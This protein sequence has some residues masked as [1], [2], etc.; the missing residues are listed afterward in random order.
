MAVL[1]YLRRI[2]ESLDHPDMI[3][4]I[5]HYLLALPN[6]L[7][8]QL[9]SKSSVSDARKRKS[10]DL[11]SMMAERSDVTVTPLL[12]N[13][14]DLIL[15]CLRSH[16]QQTIHVT[17]QLVSAI[18]KRHHRYAVITLLKTEILPPNNLR[19]TIGAHEQEV[20]YIMSLAG[21]IGG[22]T[23]FDDIY[24]DVLRDTMSRL[25]NHPCSIKMVAPR[26]STSNQRL[27][28]SLPGAPKDV[29][30]HTLRP[31]DPLLN[32]LL[33]LLETFF[34]NPVETNLSVTETLVDLAV[35]GYMR[36]EGWLIRNPR[37]YTYYEVE[38]ATEVKSEAEVQ[39]V[40]HVTAPPETQTEPIIEHEDEV[41]QD[42][43]ATR[44]EDAVGD[45]EPNPESSAESPGEGEVEA[46]TQSEAEPKVA[47]ETEHEPNAEGETEA[48]PKAD[49]EAKPE[50]EP[51][52]EPEVETEAEVSGMAEPEV[53]EP[54]EK[55]EGQDPEAQDESKPKAEVEAEKPVE[56]NEVSM[57]KDKEESA[58]A[59]PMEVP[60]TKIPTEPKEEEKE[61]PH[62]AELEQVEKMK[63]CREW[64]QWTQASAPRVMNVLKHLE[65]QVLTYKKTIPRFDE[66]VQQRREAF[67]TADAM[68][69]TPQ[70]SYKATPIQQDTPDRSSFEDISRS[71]SPSRPSAL[72]GLA[73]R[74]LSELGTPSRSS[75]PRG[76]KELN[77]SSASGGATPSSKPSLTPN[78]ELSHHHLDRRKLA[79]SSSPS[80][81]SPN[82]SRDE[83]YFS[84]GRE[85]IVSSQVAAFAAI[86]QTILARKVGLPHDKVE[87]IPLKFDRDPIPEPVEEEPE[88]AAEDESEV[89][90]PS[91]DENAPAVDPTVSVSHLVTNVI[92]LQSFLFELASLVQVRAGLFDEV[93][94]I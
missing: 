5:L 55:A 82:K 28:D 65:D 85:A 88:Q 70:P 14:V 83:S 69:Q 47:S 1:T 17:L 49:S 64:P 46:E 81:G 6:A 27:P 38:V 36:I 94:F 87:P 63:R 34:I 77:R 16:N 68:L 78:P 20:E 48:Q 33:D 92:V 50:A 75:S 66:L 13:L 73:H 72:E 44:A 39:P 53:V 86:D 30:E 42:D 41:K 9:R 45:N 43:G 23:N 80:K 61:V 74:L 89:D 56:S 22:Q 51:E 11:A 19:R 32:S 52:L 60:E 21:S 31:D 4:L 58:D 59:S 3:N 8:Y 93:R 18:L 62:A 15:A 12:F 37:S 67:Q 29:T 25:E 26:I 90:N 84:P 35:C 24:Q 91:A 54:E 2:L 57:D 10:M 76:R 79:R 7:P 71:A 40:T